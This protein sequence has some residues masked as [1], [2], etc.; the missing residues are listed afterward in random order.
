MHKLM[1]IKNDISKTQKHF[2]L[3]VLISF[4]RSLVTPDP[5]NV[6]GSGLTLGL[7]RIYLLR[8]TL[9]TRPLLTLRSRSK[10]S[11]NKH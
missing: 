9:Y 1:K 5:S 7:I 11:G 6:K 2:L 8:N 3:S 10:S 4:P